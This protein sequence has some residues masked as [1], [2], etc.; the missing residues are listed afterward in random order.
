[1]TLTDFPDWGGIVKWNGMDVLLYWGPGGQLFLTDVSDLDQFKASFEPLQNRA[2]ELPIYHLPKE[3]ATRIMEF[4]R[5][6]PSPEK[7]LDDLTLLAIAI[8]A[9]LAWRE[10]K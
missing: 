9:F 8:L 7:A 2:S 3:V 10:L 1:M 4:L 6:L 5:N